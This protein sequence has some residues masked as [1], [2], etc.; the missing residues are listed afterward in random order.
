MLRARSFYVYP[1]ERAFAG[2]RHQIM[3]AQQE[4][5]ALLVRKVQ[6][7]AGLSHG[8]VAGREQFMS[9]MAVALMDDVLEVWSLF[10][11][12][13]SVVVCCCFFGFFHIPIPSGWIMTHCANYAVMCVVWRFAPLQEVDHADIP[14][15]QILKHA[16]SLLIPDDTHLKQIV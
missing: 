10:V 4:L 11:V 3:K 16:T 9:L 8:G 7:Q 2:E 15:E 1:K 5:E 14:A 13:G 12:I 6:R